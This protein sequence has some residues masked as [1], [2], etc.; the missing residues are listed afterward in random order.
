[1][2]IPPRPSSTSPTKIRSRSCANVRVLRAGGV[3]RL[4]VPDL[5]KFVA[6][7]LAS[8]DAM[9]SHR[10]VRRL[11][12]HS[13]YHDLFHPGAHHRQMF[14]CKSLCQ[15]LRT[16]GFANPEEKPFGESRIPQIAEVEMKIRRQESL[17]VECV[18]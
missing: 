2:F 6:D 5:R 8:D 1:M 4:A 10:F 11:Q 15:M 18:K 3:L 7:Y 14:D 16:A 13:T 9:A 17:Y 12:L